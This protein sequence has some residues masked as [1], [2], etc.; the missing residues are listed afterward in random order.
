[1]AFDPYNLSALAYANGFTL[2]HYRTADPLGDL[3]QPGYFDGSSNML[4]AG[5]MIFANTGNAEAILVVQRN[6][7]G[8]VLVGTV[9]MATAEATHA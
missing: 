9:V 2:W 4:R 1:M 7:A 6:E 8:R 5:D 3:N